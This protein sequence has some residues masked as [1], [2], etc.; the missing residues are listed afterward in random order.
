MEQS[1]RDY[2][3]ERVHH[4]AA[5]PGFTDCWEWT[6]AP[7]SSGYGLSKRRDRLD[8][9][10]RIAYT[11]FVGPIPGGCQVDHLCFNHICVNPDHLEAVTQ[12]VNLQRMH[13]KKTGRHYSIFQRASNGIWVASIEVGSDGHRKK[14]QFS[15][16]NRDV[17][18]AKADAF[19]SDKLDGV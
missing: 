10:H 15:S 8:Y 14:R 2:I 7:G 5:V 16:M 12:L 1:I 18:M 3:L 9:A 11:E 13:L 6:L 4:R 17:A 19:I